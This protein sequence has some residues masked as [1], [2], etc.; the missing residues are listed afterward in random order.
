MKLKLTSKEKESLN[1]LIWWK[2]KSGVF[3]VIS[4]VAGSILSIPALGFKCEAIFLMLTTLLP[5]S[6]IA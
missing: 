5:T 1:L 3:P 6:E 4:R 2:A